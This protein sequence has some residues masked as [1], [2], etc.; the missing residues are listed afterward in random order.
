[1]RLRRSRWQQAAGG[2][3]TLLRAS[4]FLP[5]STR[6]P[7]RANPPLTDVTDGVCSM[8]VR[9][10]SVRVA[11]ISLGA[12]ACVAAGSVYTI[13]DGPP[14]PPAFTG[15]T[16]SWR[17]GRVMVRGV[18][19]VRASGRHDYYVEPLFRLD[20]GQLEHYYDR[21]Y[22]HVSE[23]ATIAW[24]ASVPPNW[25]GKKITYCSARGAALTGNPE[26]D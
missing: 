24:H 18:M 14:V 16:C 19:H 10:P 3:A 21:F 25:P 11:L 7:H 2:D 6:C 5:D 15:V 17:S 12:A 26:D 22:Y 20:D 1:M 13:R 23:G 4:S 8:C 9:R